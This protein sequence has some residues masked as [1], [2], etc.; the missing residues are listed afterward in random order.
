VHKI[1]MCAQI[2]K[3]KRERRGKRKKK[4]ISWFKR[5]GGGGGNLAQLGSPAGAGPHASEGERN[6]VT[7]GDGGPPAV[8]RNRPPVI[9]FWVI[10][11][12]A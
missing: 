6:G 4:R 9:R 5:A 3:R 10:G 7:G 12:V 8:G 11:E 1:S 2:Y